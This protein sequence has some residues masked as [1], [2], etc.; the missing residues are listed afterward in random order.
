MF[1][2]LCDINVVYMCDVPWCVFPI[3]YISTYVI[4]INVVYSNV[5]LDVPSKNRKK[6]V[7]HAAL[8]AHSSGREKDR[9]FVREKSIVRN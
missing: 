9:A 5:F 8:G 3:V 6:R 1:N 7:T 2:I 4:L